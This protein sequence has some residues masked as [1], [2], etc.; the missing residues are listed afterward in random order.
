MKL[1]NKKTREIGTPR[2]DYQEF[3]IDTENGYTYCYKSLQ[4]MYEEWEDY[5]EAKERYW[6]IDEDGVLVCR[7]VGDFTNEE[8]CKQIG[9]YFA[10][11]EEAEKAVGKLKAITRLKDKG[12]RFE[13]VKEGVMGHEVKIYARFMNLR[14][15]E[16]DTA[17][18]D[19]QKDLETCFGGEE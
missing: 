1:Q 15:D 5:E 13:G 16:I 9:N 19:N 3:Y 10:T 6:V 8:M 4:R 17:F 18:F 14:K 2:V 11:K 7:T 12:F